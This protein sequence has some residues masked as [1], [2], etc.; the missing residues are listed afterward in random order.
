MNVKELDIDKLAL[1]LQEAEDKRLGGEPLTQLKEDLTTEE[2]YQV[3]FKVIQE[4]VKKGHR[5]VGKKIGLT[6]EAMQKGF[7]IDT[8]DCGHLLDSM[9]VQN[10]GIVSPHQVIQPKIEAE[11]AFVLK[12]DLL[13]SNITLEDVLEATDYIVPSIEIVDS[14]I[15]NWNIKLQDTIADNASAGLYILGENK[16]S[17]NDVDIR[18]VRMKLYKNGELVNEGLGSDAMGPPGICVAWLAKQ[19]SAFG[20]PLRA[21]EVIL[22][23]ALALTV[24]ANPGD[25]FCA[26][27]DQLGEVEI[28]F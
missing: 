25:H 20:V 9:E 16:V 3:Q 22:S 1:Y 14:R 5:I 26:K 27:F 15:A 10:K 7:G 13:G 17:I 23:G 21:G 4:K 18:K 19:M 11:I 2:A 28:T 24:D 8:P 6:S 12:K